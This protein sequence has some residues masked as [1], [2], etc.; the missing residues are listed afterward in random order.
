MY[1][2]EAR[3]DPTESI[4]NSLNKQQ[5][6]QSPTISY[7]QFSN[8]T[9]LKSLDTM[10]RYA[11]RYAIKRGPG[12][13]RPTALEIVKDEGLINK[14]TDKVMIV[15]GVSSGVGVETL[16]AFH[17]TGAT[18]YGTVRNVA[19]G[20]KVVDEIIAADP[21]NKAKIELL[22]IDLESFDSIKKGV[23]EFLK[24]ESK[25][26]ILVNNAGIMAVDEG[27]TKDGWERQ[28]GTNHFGHFLLFHLLK[29]TLLAS[30]TPEFPSRVVSVASIGHRLAPINFD[31]INQEGG[32]YNPWVAYSYSKTANIWFANELERRYGSKNLH[33]TSLHPGGVVSNL[34]DHINDPALLEI[35]D[36]EEVRNYYK[37]SA[38]GAATSVYA[39]LSQEWANKGGKYLSDCVEQRKFP[40]DEQNF[41][42]MG[43]D[44]YRAWAYDEAGERKL[45]EVSLKAIGA[46]DDQ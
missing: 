19:K 24:K 16:R 27:R 35:L 42:K 4:N 11:E 43:D 1:I 8:T 12:D 18:V 2:V 9:T 39:A 46:E 32:V 29:D 14:L 30:A 20:Q 45:W 6:E 15:T 34:A 31:N 40:D 37:N 28:I 5:V 26:N 41:L 23:A 44:G 21:D 33:A 10:S 13:N 36:T 7:I 17:A 3:T 25:L 38:Q 22:E